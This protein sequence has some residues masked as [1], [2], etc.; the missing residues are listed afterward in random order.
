MQFNEHLYEY[1]MLHSNLSALSVLSW[2]R[3]SSLSSSS[4]PIMI[5]LQGCAC[6]RAHSSV[7]ASKQPTHT[8]TLFT[9]NRFT[10]HEIYESFE[11]LSFH[12]S[13]VCVYVCMGKC[14]IAVMH[15]ERERAPHAMQPAAS[16]PAAAVGFAA[17]A[18]LMGF[19]AGFLFLV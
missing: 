18:S 12:C 7:P 5:V 4:S 10:Q 11:Q 8:C 14:I 15:T 9:F 19:S 17:R 16:Q 13:C 3:V 6:S 2:C 1:F